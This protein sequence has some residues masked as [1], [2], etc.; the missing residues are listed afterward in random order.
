MVF[1]GI[2]IAALDFYEDLEADNSKSFWTAHKHVY[3]E[4]VR[5]P[6]DALVAELAPEFGAAKLFRPYRDVRFAKDKTPY[7]TH[8]GVWFGESSTYLHVSAAG[9]FVGGGY[10]D[11]TSEQVT[12]FRRAIDDDVAGP[13]LERAIA[14]V[15]KLKMEL[16]GNQLTRVPAGYPKDHPRADLLRYK[17]LTAHRELGAPSWLCTPKAKTE[18]TK[19]FRSLAPLIDWL[20]N[21]VGRD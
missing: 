8:Q 3:D 14:A 11:E 12:R 18:I 1:A 13:A 15:T 5:G 4:S 9:L 7:K 19:A 16:A 2:P 6:I 20:D 17:S 21:N 10:W